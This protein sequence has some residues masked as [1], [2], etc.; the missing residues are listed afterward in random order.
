VNKGEPRPG[1]HGGE[2]RATALFM[3]GHVRYLEVSP[4]QAS[5]S[6]YTLLFESSLTSGLYPAPEPGP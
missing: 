1:D 4:G 2:N 3:D 5:G 6:A